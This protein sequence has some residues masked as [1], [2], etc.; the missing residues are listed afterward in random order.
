MN[1]PFLFGQNITK[2]FFVPFLQ[3][4]YQILY[5]GRPRERERDTI[6]KPQSYEIPHE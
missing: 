3:I 5:E 6:E 2:N 4:F 1:Q